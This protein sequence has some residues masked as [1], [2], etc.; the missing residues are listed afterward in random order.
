MRVPFPWIFSSKKRRMVPA[1]R[2][3][4]D[5]IMIFPPF[6]DKSEGYGVKATLGRR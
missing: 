5:D 6:G 2:T 4:D 3:I 1:L